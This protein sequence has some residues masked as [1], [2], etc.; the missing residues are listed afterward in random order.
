MT[1]PKEMRG[2]QIVAPGRVEV[3]TVGTPKP[4]RGEVL[5]RVRAVSVCTHWDLTILA[6]KDIF[7]R[8]GYPKYPIPVGI[9]G[10]EMSGEVVALGE[11]VTALRVGDRVATWSSRASQK[12]IGYYAQYAAVPEDCLLTIPNNLSFVHAAPLEMGMSVAGS[13]RAMGDLAGK[14]VAV[15]GAGPAGLIGIG[16]IRALGARQIL[17]FDPL[18]K[19]RKLALELGADRALDPSSQ[20]SLA[21]SP[22]TAQVALECA[23]N[24]AS[25]ENLMRVT[26]G[27]VHLFGVVHGQI[28]YGIEHWGRGVTLAGYP[29]HSVESGEFARAMMAGGAVRTDRIIGKTVGFA[30]YLDGIEVLKTGAIPKL[31]VVPE[32][33]E[34]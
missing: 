23:G 28:R 1:I 22:R 12:T 9:P 11:G 19:R 3:V 25:A 21:L 6:G 26:T 16:M 4:A 30:D 32:G 14:C 24:A 34:E 17:V 27:A 10:H 29:G 8:P 33:N 31:C 7:E 15:G 20:E 13:V 18:E 5:V 2:L